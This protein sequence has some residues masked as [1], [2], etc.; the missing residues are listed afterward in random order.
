MNFAKRV[1]LAAAIYG[2][3]VLLP[4]YFTEAR[5]SQQHPPPITHPEYYYGFVGVALAW[6]IVFLVIHS[7]PER[8]R[9][10]MLVSIAEKAAFAVAVP[11]LYALGRTYGQMLAAGLVDAVWGVLFAT[12]Y[13][14][15]R[16]GT[17]A[18]RADR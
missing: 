14:K 3:V 9:P 5:T 4:M 1:F 16:P 8:Y 7:D 17:A 11:V 10:L 13:V 2:V 15:T 18:A 12:A 6:Q